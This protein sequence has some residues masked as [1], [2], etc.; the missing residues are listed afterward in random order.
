MKSAVAHLIYYDLGRKGRTLLV[1]LR[2]SGA[3]NVE[4]QGKTSVRSRL[5]LRGE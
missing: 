4:F 1:R 2:A 5:Y 3:L